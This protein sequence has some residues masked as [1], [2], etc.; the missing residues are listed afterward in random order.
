MLGFDKIASLA[1]RARAPKQEGDG[2][3]PSTSAQDHGAAT[4]GA[5][6]EGVA[7]NDA[8]RGVDGSTTS[9]ASNARAMD[10]AALVELL[11]C[12]S[13]RLDNTVIRGLADH[14]EEVRPGFVFFA[15]AGHE[16]NGAR[17]ASRAVGNGAIAVVAQEPLPVPVPV[18]LV[19]DVR[20]AASRA[21]ACFFGR[22]SL[23]MPVIG[24]TG[25]NGK[26]TVADLLRICLE[27]DSRPVG[28][29]GTIEYRLGS[30][31]SGRPVVQRATNTTPGPIAIQN[32]LRQMLDREV[33]AAVLEVSSHAL[34]QGRCDAVHFAAAI[35]TNLTQDHLDYHGTMQAYAEAK[36]R[37]FASLKEGTI[38]ILPADDPNAAMMR[39][40]LPDGVGIATYALGSILPDALPTEGIHVRG[41]IVQAGIDSCKIEA[42]TPEGVVSFCLPLVGEHNARNALAA[43]TAAIALG[44]GSLRVADALTCARPVAG[45]LE[46]IASDR[47]PFHVFVDYAHTPDA[48]Q[49]VL[50]ST[51]PLTAGSLRVLFGCGGDRDRD[52]RPKMGQIAAK[53]ADHVVVTSDNPRRE[54]PTAILRDILTGVED[55][56]DQSSVIEV[57][58]DRR[59]AIRHLLASSQ[60]G[61]TIVIA[62][63]GHE[64]GQVVGDVTRP[65]DDREEVEEWACSR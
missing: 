61:D 44:V 6:Q 2:Q 3:E 39:D 8:A 33:R 47:L 28:S 45:R 38:A 20:R 42:R 55:L 10:L 1:S 21:A 17:F 31:G 62:G 14:S 19:D 40:A 4:A 60:P 56:E 5:A 25:T 41:R 57:C 9:S 27:D 64:R 53:L 52:K 48:L 32:Y 11:E 43:M 35:F 15:V 12:D 37:L 58:E 29:L 18:L 24:V 59:R 46:A 49:Q 50:T 16:K 63:K 54:D 7:S 30:N 36:S 22:P 23:R 13:L 65:F 34:D 51:R 26:T